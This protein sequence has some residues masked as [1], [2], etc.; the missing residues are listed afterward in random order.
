ML[1]AILHAMGKK[2]SC[3]SWESILKVVPFVAS[4]Y[5][6]RE[7]MLSRDA[8]LT[9]K[10][11]WKISPMLA[12]LWKLTCLYV[13]CLLS[14]DLCISTHVCILYKALHAR[15][16]LGLSVGKDLQLYPPESSGMILSYN[17]YVD[18]PSIAI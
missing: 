6:S 7:K 14:N 11:I 4:P 8:E 12:I 15:I 16:W 18:T 13:C 10:V 5:T 17:Q 2:I 9:P 3:Q 1:P